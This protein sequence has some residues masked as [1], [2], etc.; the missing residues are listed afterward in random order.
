MKY[1][2]I[3]G[4]FFFIILACEVCPWRICVYNSTDGHAKRQKMCLFENKRGENPELFFVS[5]RKNNARRW[6]KIERP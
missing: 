6:R 1:T 2:T 5:E 3:S 4:C